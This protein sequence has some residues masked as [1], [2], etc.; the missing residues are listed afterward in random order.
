MRSKRASLI[1]L[2]TVWLSSSASAANGGSVTGIVLDNQGSPVPGAKVLALELRSSPH[3]LLK[4]HLADAGGRFS[5]QDLPWGTY[6][7]WAGREEKG[8]P[9]L[10]SPFYLHGSLPTVTLRPT[11]PSTSVTIRLGPKAGAIEAVGL[12]DSKT[13]RQVTGVI[14]LQRGADRESIM[15]ASTTQKPILIPSET[16]VR[17]AVAASGYKGWPA[18]GGPNVAGTLQLRPEEGVE[19]AVKLAPEGSEEASVG[20]FSPAR[21]SPGPNVAVPA[22]AEGNPIL[23]KAVKEFRVTGSGISAQV[24]QLAR[25]FKVPMG[26][27]LLRA[28]SDG[29]SSARPISVNV[30]NVTVRDVLDAIVAADPGYEWRQSDFGTIAVFPVSHTPSLGD[31]VVGRYSVQNANRDQAIEELMRAPE[32]V[33]WVASAGVERRGFG[34]SLTSEG[35]KRPGSTTSLFSISLSHASVR[36]VLNAILIASDSRYWMLYRHGSHQEFVSLTL[37][38]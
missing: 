30:E 3:R 19:L 34:G 7:M 11:S 5:I 37:S 8:Y 24:E 26:L 28:P 12:V 10:P 9:E 1:L 21:Y 22:P 25:R 2:M 33:R 31:V 23:A 32:V 18:S 29:T 38:D 14:T 13:G 36:T 17:V 20:G 35:A 4:F 6:S 16:E 27:E 15:Q